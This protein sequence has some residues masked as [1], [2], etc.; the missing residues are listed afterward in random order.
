MH[1]SHIAV[2]FFNTTFLIVGYELFHWNFTHYLLNEPTLGYCSNIIL[3][4]YI[5]S[6]D[7]LECI[8]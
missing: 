2:L 8:F 3:L 6:N 1:Q 4:D 7:F 5:Y